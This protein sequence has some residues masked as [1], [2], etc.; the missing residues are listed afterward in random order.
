MD[1]TEARD[2]LRHVDRIIAATD[3]TVRVPPSTLIAIG[4]ICSALTGMQQ[5][6]LLGVAVPPDQYVHLPMIAGIIGIAVISGRRSRQEGRETLVAR[7]AGT[8]FLLAFVVALTLNVTAQHRI[9]SAEG[10]GLVWS[11]SFAL[12]LLMAG[13]MGSRVLFAGGAAMLAATATA[14]LVPGWL[15]GVLA[16]GWFLG[17]AVPGLVLARGTQDGRTAAV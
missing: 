16:A 3:R 17:Y 1:T 4:L 15:P 7:Y 11:A 2:H 10:M 6:R 12:A 8:A 9:I 13:A 5:A 14:S